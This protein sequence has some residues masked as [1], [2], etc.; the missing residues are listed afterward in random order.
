M[1]RARPGSVTVNHDDS[2]TTWHV[3]GKV[4]LVSTIIRLMMSQSTMVALILTW[5]VSQGVV[6]VN[7]DED[8]THVSQG[9]LYQPS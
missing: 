6:S 4:C 9:V 8:M 7:H 2:N 5:N 3:L 1:P